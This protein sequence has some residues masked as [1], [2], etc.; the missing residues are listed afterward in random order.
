MSVLRLT[1]EQA[2]QHQQRVKGQTG[3]KNG[4][5]KREK[6]KIDGKSLKQRSKYGN[7]KVVDADGKTVDSKK[8]QR[9]RQQL[10]ARFRAGEIT[11]LAE[12]VWVRLSANRR[13]VVDF[14]YVEADGTRRYVD[15]KGYATPAWKLKQDWARELGI[16]VETI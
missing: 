8:E 15:A 16:E 9:I 11:E 13:M 6:G 7:E 12:Q 1:P 5:K 4:I 2:A 3:I 14:V 10:R